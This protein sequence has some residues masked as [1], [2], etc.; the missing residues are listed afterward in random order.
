MRRLILHTLSAEIPRAAVVGDI[1]GCADALDALLERL[2]DDRPLFFVG[3]LID[4]GPDSRGVVERLIARGARGVCGNHELWMRSWLRGEELDTSV[5][6]PGFGAAPTLRSYGLPPRSATLQQPARGRIPSAHREFFLGLP[7]VLELSVGGEGYWLIHAGLPSVTGSAPGEI[8]AW[9][10]TCGS[11]LLWHGEAPERRPAA[12]K[13]VVMGHV[14]QPHVKDLG[15]LIA[16]D[17]GAGL[18]DA[19]RLSAILLP[20]RTVLSTPAPAPS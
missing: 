11:R 9:M 1:H 17:T 2:P 14:P 4:R 18:W 13:T 10:E 8:R 3:A 6:L 5:L 7:H 16:L 20:E 15:H 19:G 12:D